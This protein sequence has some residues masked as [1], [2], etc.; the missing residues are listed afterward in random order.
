MYAWG[1]AVTLPFQTRKYKPVLEPKLTLPI[2]SPSPR[3]SPPRVHGPTTS[4]FRGGG[5][6]LSMKSNWR[7]KPCGTSVSNQPPTSI[8][9]GLIPFKCCQMARW[10]DF[11]ISRVFDVEQPVGLLVLEVL[12]VGIGQ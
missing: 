6:F 12:F 8:T 11:V 4:M 3:E 5:Q 2:R 10:P 1:L 9:A 7:N